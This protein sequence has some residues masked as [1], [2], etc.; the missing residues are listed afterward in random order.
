MPPSLAQRIARA[1]H[2]ID[3]DAAHARVTAWLDDIADT[4]AGQSLARL[5]A[6]FPTV[7]TLLAALADGS[8]Y[9]WDLVRPIRR[10]SPR[11]SRADPDNGFDETAHRGGAGGRGH[12]GRRRGDAAAA[13]DEGRRPRC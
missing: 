11:C 9:L 1:P 8:P 3:A 6:D 10:G 7:G 13:P 4:A 2:L 12:P 5:R